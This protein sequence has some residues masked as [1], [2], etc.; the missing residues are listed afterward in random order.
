MHV[1]VIRIAHV[2]ATCHVN[3]KEKAHVQILMTSLPSH[4][5]IA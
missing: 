5:K 2:R 3:R 1:D 4:V